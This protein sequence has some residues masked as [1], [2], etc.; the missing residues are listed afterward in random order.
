MEVEG[1]GEGR[2]KEKKRK[3]KGKNKGKKKGKEK[4]KDVS[5]TQVQHG[6]KLVR[7]QCFGK[8]DWHY[9]G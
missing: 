1:E 4:K 5:N 6:E 9:N 8:G 3:N 7:E 2:K